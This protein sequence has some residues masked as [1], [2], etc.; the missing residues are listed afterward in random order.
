MKLT[1]AQQQIPAIEEFLSHEYLLSNG[2][3]GYAS[4]SL[5]DCHTRKYHG[6]LAVPI[7][8]R[9]QVY[10]LLSKLELSILVGPNQYDLST[11]S[12]PKVIFPQGYQFIQSIEVDYFPVTTYSAGGVVI[13]KSTLMVRGE[14]TV[15]VRYQI[16]QAQKTVTI[17]IAPFLAYRDIHGLAHINVEIR[18][19]TYFEETGF[20]IDPYQNLPALYIQTSKTSI[21]YPSPDWWRNYE[22]REEQERGYDFQEDLFTPGIF[23]IKLKQG[24]AVIVRSSLSSCA[25]KTIEAAWNSE[26][27]RIHG[28][29]E[30]YASDHEPLRTFKVQA[31]HFV[32]DE[33]KGVVAGYPWFDAEWGRDTMISLPGLLLARGLS[34]EAFGILV[35][36]AGLEKDG[37]LPNTV[38]RLGAHAYNSVDT[39]FLFF[40]AVQRYL[41]YT[42]DN[43][44]VEKMLFPTMEKILSRFMEGNVPFAHIGEDGL[45]Y[46]GNDTTQLTWMDAVARGKPVTTRHG[47]AVEVNALFYNAMV[48]LLEQFQ[49]LLHPDKAK[50]WDRVRMLFEKNFTRCF[51]NDEFG[52]L[53]DV[54]RG[55]GDFDPSLRP[56][57]L[58]AVGLPNICIDG[59]KAQAIID[60]VKISLVTPYGLRTLAPRDELFIPLYE[61]DQEKRDSAYHQG[62]VW[63]WLIGIFFDAM[64][65]NA[66]DKESVKTYFRNTF[67]PLWDL[68]G[69]AKCLQHI[70]EM[71]TPLS[72]HLP[73]GCP[74][75]AWSIAEVIRVLEAIK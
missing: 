48:F 7:P 6:L 35:K 36:Y 3:G 73:K 31:A 19:R 37:L 21:F 38:A 10:M 64:K 68:H 33:P 70:A 55:L 60:A 23:E 27:E 34:Q 49:T 11:N 71:Y 44:G 30:C 66:P 20:K 61:G 40:W 52:F 54:Y 72:P 4:S 5:L 29:E 8:A 45:L 62:M 9:G 50:T 42:G 25:P 2:K 75:Q 56:N 74:A 57:Q 47:A 69:E 14:D 32:T 39:P 43:R 51:W 41:A 18:P 17:K 65:K 15:L 67:S 46:A 53:M 13:K 16:T 26:I 28:L 59:E 1:F 22:Y 58:F 63:P 12:F 24:E